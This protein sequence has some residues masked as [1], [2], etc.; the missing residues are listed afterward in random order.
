VA[1]MTIAVSVARSQRE[2]ACAGQVFR[3]FFLSQPIVDWVAVEAELASL[4]EHFLPPNGAAVLGMADNEVAGAV[5]V[6]RSDATSARMMHLYVRPEARRRALGRMLVEQAC[7][8]ACALG[9][10]RLWLDTHEAMVEAVA[11]YR[12]A[13]FRSF[14]VETKPFPGSLFFECDL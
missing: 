3:E 4:H 6:Q 8:A 14:T 12:S 5:G 2:L 11:L 13:G 1:R 9:C 10:T 7:V